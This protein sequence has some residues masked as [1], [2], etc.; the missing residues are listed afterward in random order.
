MINLILLFPLIACIFLFI[1]KKKNLNNFILTSYAILHIIISS[2]AC[3]KVDL[4]PLW[5]TCSFFSFTNR[6][7]LFLLVLSIVFLAVAIYS[8]G[9]IKGETS[10]PRKQRHFTYMTMLFVLSMTG[11]VLS[12]NLGVSWV[13]IEGTTLA[14]ENKENIEEELL[15]QI[16]VDYI[17]GR[18]TPVFIM[19]SAQ[20]IDRL[21][22][23]LFPRG[24]RSEP[25]Q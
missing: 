13:F 15:E 18:S 25:S 4:L 22:T 21:I 14:R 1:F 5:K 7:V 16:A 24:L 20:N 17:K 12:T 11:A 8:N 19:M 23:Y 3:L 2:A 6:N 9:Y 10:S